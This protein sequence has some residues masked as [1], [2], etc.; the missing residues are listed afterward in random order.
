MMSL[1]A[2][3]KKS[4]SNDNRMHIRLWS[5]S[6]SHERVSGGRVLEFADLRLGLA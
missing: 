5:P 6:G 2:K 4:D 1:Q 3:W